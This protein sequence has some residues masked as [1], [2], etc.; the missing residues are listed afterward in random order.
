M[1]KARQA[2]AQVRRWFRR[3]VQPTIRLRVVV[4]IPKRPLPQNAYLVI[5]DGIEEYLALLCPC[6]CGET[7]YLNLLP[8][9]RPCWRLE[10][11]RNQ[12]FSVH[13]SV[14]RT[15]GCCSHFFLRAGKVIWYRG[16]TA[17]Y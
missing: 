12:T 1:G 10:R 6:R 7:I 16:R 9:D 8:D 4:S 3:F 5:E 11:G 14:W 2:A 15:T 13:P 17:R